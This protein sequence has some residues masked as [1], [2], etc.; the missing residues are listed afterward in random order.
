M[1][2][3]IPDLQMICRGDAGNRI[4]P[5]I[6]PP[7]FHHLVILVFHSTQRRRLL[8]GET[9]PLPQFAETFSEEFGSGKMI[10][11]LR[12]FLSPAGTNTAL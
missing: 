2:H 5:H 6:L 11:H 10:G 4:E 3:Q 12:R 8:L 7:P 1:L 9:M